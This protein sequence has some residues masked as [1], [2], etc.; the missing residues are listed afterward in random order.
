MC[1]TTIPVDPFPPLFIHVCPRN[2]LLLLWCF[3]WMWQMKIKKNIFL[4]KYQWNFFFFVLFKKMQIHYTYVGTYVQKSNTYFFE[5]YK[6][7]VCQQFRL[8]NMFHFVPRKCLWSLLS[9]GE[10]AANPTQYTLSSNGLSG[11]LMVRDFSPIILIHLLGHL[12]CYRGQGSYQ[13]FS[14]AG[15]CLDCKEAWAICNNMTLKW[16]C[17]CF[18]FFIF[19]FFFW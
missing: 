18:F 14:E 10:N 4:N 8:E 7:S 5:P 16:Y 13:E 2:M 17:L 1:P 19:F 9:L 12:V 15:S 11:G 6:Q 3:E